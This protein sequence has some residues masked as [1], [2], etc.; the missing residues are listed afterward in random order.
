M[1]LQEMSFD[2]TKVLY[3]SF[4]GGPPNFHGFG[5]LMNNFLKQLS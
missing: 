3:G 1:S 2:F 5:Y 4:A